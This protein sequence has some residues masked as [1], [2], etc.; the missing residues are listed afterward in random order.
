MTQRVCPAEHVAPSLDLGPDVA[1]G[2]GQGLRAR[3]GGEAGDSDNVLRATLGAEVHGEG[4]ALN[5][6][7]WGVEMRSVRQRSK[8]G[9]PA[10]QLAT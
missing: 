8:P 10:P 5:L 7:E 6:S 1:V 9:Y 3:L 2:E 4:A